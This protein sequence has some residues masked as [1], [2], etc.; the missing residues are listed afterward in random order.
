MKFISYKYKN[1]ENYGIYDQGKVIPIQYLLENPPPTLLKFIEGGYRVSNS[2]T[3]TSYLSLEDIEICAPIINPKRNLFCVG[4]NYFEH[5]NEIE[6]IAGLNASV[7]KY[8][9]YFGK[10]ADKIIGSYDSILSHPEITKE[11]DY[12]VELAVIIGKDGYK[13]KQE[14]VSSHIFGYSIANDVSARDIQINHEQWLLGKSLPT[15]C[16]MGPVIVSSEELPLPLELDLT[17]EVNNEI[18]QSSNTKHMIFNIEALIEKL[19]EVI[20]LRA[21]DII[22]TGTPSGVG[23]GFSPCKYLRSGDV[24]R[25]S[26]DKIGE[27]VNNIK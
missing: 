25:C 1:L 6:G 20:T 12:E 9:V 15:F 5:A 13:I 19:S 22:L 11:V 14:N 17:C 21:G 10:I 23:M 3:E 27:L 7:P 18:R 4:K 26:I 8:P 16:S 2:R 24:V